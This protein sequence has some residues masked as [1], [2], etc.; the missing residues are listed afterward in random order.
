MTRKNK[1]L[2]AAWALGVVVLGG[3]TYWS[4]DSQSRSR[5][6][7]PYGGQ[8]G[9]GQGSWG[10]PG[11]MAPYPSWQADTS[12]LSREQAAG[13]AAIQRDL[14]RREDELARRLWD[15]QTRLQDMY[16]RDT[17]DTRAMGEVYA[18]IT[19]LQRQALVARIEAENRIEALLAQGRG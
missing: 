2:I 19:E 13:I 8:P 16:L 18:R 1:L 7:G 10:G 12:G 3:L 15:E 6:H 11:A 14:A 4:F 5:W 9:Y 17:P